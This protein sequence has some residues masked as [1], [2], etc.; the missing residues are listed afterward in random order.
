MLI[1]FIKRILKIV[2]LT[3]LNI[4]LYFNV[5]VIVQKIV[6][7]CFCVV[8]M[9]NKFFQRNFYLLNFLLMN[10][11]QI[12]QRTNLKKLLEYIDDSIK[13]MNAG[14]INVKNNLESKLLNSTLES[15]FINFKI[16]KTKI[17]R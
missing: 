13:Q 6:N 15:Q 7:R 4:E 9:Q 17:L 3:K 14:L 2:F 8:K 5:I 16:K 11:K 10:L 12:N 1:T